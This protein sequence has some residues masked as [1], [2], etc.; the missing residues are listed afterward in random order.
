MITN[1]SE[2]WVNSHLQRKKNPQ[3]IIVSAWH[4][5][6]L[7]AGIALQH[8]MFMT[9]EC[10]IEKKEKRYLLSEAKWREK[11]LQWASCMSISPFNKNNPKY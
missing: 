11:L 6:V 5:K 8:S 9:K 1:S 7:F 4:I 10:G 3:K 2:H